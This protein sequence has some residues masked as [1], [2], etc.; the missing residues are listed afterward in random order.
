[1]SIG[2]IETTEFHKQSLSD[3]GKKSRHQ[4]VIEMWKIMVKFSR[5]ELGTRTTSEIGLEVVYVIHYPKGKKSQHLT[6]KTFRRL[7]DSTPV[8]LVEEIPRQC[9]R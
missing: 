5:F 3:S 6:P 8:D 1:M 4:N 9:S 2:A 7:R